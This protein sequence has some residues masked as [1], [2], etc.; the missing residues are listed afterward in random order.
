MYRNRFAIMLFLTLLHLLWPVSN[1]EAYSVVTHRGL[2]NMAIQNSYLSDANY[3]KSIGINSIEEEFNSNN[4]IQWIEQGADE[5]DSLLTL[6]PRN[7][8]HNPLRSWADAG[9]DDSLSGQSSLLW[10]QE[11][12]NEFSW[13]NARQYFHNALTSSS[14]ESRET[15]FANTFETNIFF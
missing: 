7:H 2:S 5:E 9:L 4:P 8:F 15:G 11:A 12:S 13:Q 14:V 3:L 1:T 10:A 6:R